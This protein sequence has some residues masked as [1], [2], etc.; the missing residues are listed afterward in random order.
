MNPRLNLEATNPLYVMSTEIIIWLSKKLLTDSKICGRW[1]PSLDLGNHLDLIQKYKIYQYT[2][3]D[4]Q[5]VILLC[6]L[7]ICMYLRSILQRLKLQVMDQQSNYFQRFE[8]NDQRVQSRTHIHCTVS[9][10]NN[11]KGIVIDTD[12]GLLKF[13]YFYFCLL[14]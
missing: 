6:I 4:L 7:C 3:N 12:V 5:L 11:K 9:V 14:V 13:L 8:K 2:S 10:I 1:H